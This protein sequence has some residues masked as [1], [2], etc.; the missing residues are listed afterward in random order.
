MADRIVQLTDKDGNNIFPTLGDHVPSVTI[1]DVDPGEGSALAADN[2]VAVYGTSPQIHTADIADE[3]VTADK[4]DFGTF[5]YPSTGEQIVGKWPDGRYIYRQ[6]VSGTYTTTSS[7]VNVIMTS[8]ANAKFIV[9]VEGYWSPNSTPTSNPFYCKW[10]GTDDF[11][12]DALVGVDVKS[13]T[14]EIR[15]HVISSVYNNYTG[16]YGLMLY[17]VKNT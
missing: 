2:Y 16:C 4:I 7:G 10:I 9:K 8:G 12:G 5:E 1:T 14:H 15:L 17:Y 6:Y 3:A 11:N 13:D